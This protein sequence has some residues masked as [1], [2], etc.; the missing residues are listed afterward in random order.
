MRNVTIVRGEPGFRAVA[1]ALT[2]RFYRLRATARGS[3][4]LLGAPCRADRDRKGWNFSRCSAVS[5]WGS[6]PDLGCSA[7]EALSWFLIGLAAPV[8]G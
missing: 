4:Q 8:M 7:S 5:F 2:G 1:A 3:K 6:G